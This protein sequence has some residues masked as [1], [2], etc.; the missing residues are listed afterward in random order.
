M[1]LSS[2]RSSSISFK[3]R[4]K[5][6]KRQGARYWFAGATSIQAPMEHAP[7]VFIEVIDNGCGM[8]AIVQRRIFEP[9]FTTKKAGTGLGLAA[10]KG[11]ADSHGATI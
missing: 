9:F 6:V 5:P 8:D 7:E 2:I 10:V 11:I 1:P 4:W 3:T